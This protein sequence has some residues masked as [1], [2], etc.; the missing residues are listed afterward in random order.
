MALVR[1]GQI[2]RAVGLKG[3]VGIAGS[4]GALAELEEIALRRG[5]GEP[6]TRRIEEARP[7][8]RIWAVK[9]EGVADRT[10]AEALVGAEVL[11]RREDLGDPGEGRHW[12][13]DLEGLPV[14]TAAGEAVGRVTGL[15]ATGG[16][17]VLVVT[18][19]RGEKLIPLAPYVEVDREGRRIVVDPPEGLLE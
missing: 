12:W 1:L 15:Y 16:V 13:A 3:H 8:G 5:D 17:D 19:E 4:E 2:V 14:V 7:Q 6:E 11:A 18:G 9:I 10:A